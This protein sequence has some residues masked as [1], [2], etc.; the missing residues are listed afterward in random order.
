MNVDDAARVAVGVAGICAEAGAG[1]AVVEAH[2]GMSTAT[3]FEYS[4]CNPL[5]AWTR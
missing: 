1:E 4:V 3:T 5:I 2:S